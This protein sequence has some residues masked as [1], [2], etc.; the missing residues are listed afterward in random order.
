M[1]KNKLIS[2][3]V[4]AATV[5]GLFSVP[6]YAADNVL[7]TAFSLDFEDAEYKVQP[8]LYHGNSYSVV[9]NGDE[10]KASA[11]WSL[12]KTVDGKPL[13]VAGYDGSWDDKYA[14]NTTYKSYLDENAIFQGWGGSYTAA[15]LS[16]M[17][18]FALTDK[19]DDVYVGLT[20]SV[21]P[22][23]PSSNQVNYDDISVVTDPTNPSN[24][25]LKFAPPVMEND[26]NIGNSIFGKNYVDVLGKQ[27][28]L[29]SKVYIDQEAGGLRLMLVRDVEFLRSMQSSFN[30]NG[31][32]KQTD[33]MQSLKN[34][35]E[36][37]GYW[38]DAVIFDNGR[39]YFGGENIASYNI[40]TWYTIDYSVDLTDISSPY[41]SLRVLDSEGNVLV[42]KRGAL[43]TGGTSTL[44]NILQNPFEISEDAESYG[45]M[46]AATSRLFKPEGGTYP[47]WNGN[48]SESGE[49]AYIDDVVFEEREKFALT[50]NEEEYI[51]N[52]VD[53]SGMPTIKASFNYDVDATTVTNDSAVITDNKGNTVTPLLVYGENGGISIMLM[54]LF[55][56][57]VYSVSFY[58][59]FASTTGDILPIPYTL[60][61]KTKDSISVKAN[62]LSGTTAECTFTNNT[63]GDINGIF[64]FSIKKNGENVGSRMHFKPAVFPAGQDKTVAIENIDLPAD[65]SSGNYTAEGFL[66]NSFG[67]LGAITDTIVF[68]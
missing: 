34:V 37:N 45:L 67:F 62:S 26:S 35:D 14:G 39:I 64:V 25:V 2:I 53:F 3:I 33:F 19:G 58:D 17:D 31:I 9:S 54:G 41:Q 10:W 8:E 43:A 20:S 7:T 59:S 47:Q 65:F 44:P 18:N 4:S 5:T 48:R 68:N 42:T 28:R 51:Q 60:K 11:N 21:V 13:S 52:P 56:S 12:I 29:S 30:Y 40:D 55:P 16:N 1:A 6:S 38:F 23:L 27:T 57:T 66:I 46:F 15:E 49:V 22:A 61:F 50:T 32:G 63:S 24:S 36:E